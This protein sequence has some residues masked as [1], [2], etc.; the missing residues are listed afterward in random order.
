MRLLSIFLCAFLFTASFFSC[1][2]QKSISY[3]QN[4]DSVSNEY[5][6]SHNAGY[7]TIIQPDDEL[8]ISVSSPDA[9]A[10][11]HFNLPILAGNSTEGQSYEMNAISQNTRIQ[12]YIVGKNGEIQFP[13]LGKIKLAGMTRDEAISYLEEKL[14]E[15]IKDPIVNLSITNFRVS[16]IGDVMAPGTYFF[17]G[18][19]TTILDAIAAAKDLNI[20]ARRDNILIIRN[21]EGKIERTRVDLTK[22]ELLTSEY[23]YLK[24]NDIIYV[25]PNS[26]RQKDASMG[27]AKQYNTSLITSS[28]GIALSVISTTAT[29]IIAFNK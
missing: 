19:R 12:P 1:S 10:A 18:Q 26:E 28:I 17:S 16:V 14:K 11:A 3:F 25:D 23:Y 8:A 4:I 27:Q 29:L 21:N 2:Q 13:T 5:L 15:Y 7:S 9:L 6:S 20:Q 22:A 24:Q